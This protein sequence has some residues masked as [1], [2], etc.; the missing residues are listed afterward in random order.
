MPST[1]VT[2][3]LN[4]DR[5]VT[6]QF[7]VLNLTEVEA[8]DGQYAINICNVCKFAKEP[9]GFA[10]LDG[11]PDTERYIVFAK[12]PAKSEAPPASVDVLVP[13]YLT[14]VSLGIVYRCRTCDVPRSNEGLMGT[15]HIKR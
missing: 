6:V 15:I 5:S 2:L 11:R 9:P 7:T 10:K 3:P 8:A 12:I 14:A 13:P 4:L 1:D